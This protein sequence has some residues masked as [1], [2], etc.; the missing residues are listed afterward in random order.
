MIVFHIDLDIIDVL[1]IV[2]VLIG[3]HFEVIVKAFK[4]W[5]NHE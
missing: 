3:I 1:A 4:K 2:S 5:R